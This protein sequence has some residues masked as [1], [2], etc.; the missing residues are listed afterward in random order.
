LLLA[1]FAACQPFLP[2]FCAG[3]KV[4]WLPSDIA[5]PAAWCITLQLESFQAALAVFAHHAA[6]RC[7]LVHTVG[8]SMLHACALHALQRMCRQ[9]KRPAPLCQSCMHC[10]SVTRGAARV[11]WLPANCTSCASIARSEDGVCA[12]GLCLACYNLL[13]LRSGQSLLCGRAVLTLWHALRRASKV[14]LP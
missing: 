12:S 8:M 14:A 1:L 3:S 7:S 10:S 11:V 4:I 2:C 5:V 9:S 6:W 13:W